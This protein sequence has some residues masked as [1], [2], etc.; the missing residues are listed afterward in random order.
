MSKKTKFTGECQLI[1]VGMME[2]GKCYLKVILVNNWSSHGA[3][4]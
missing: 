3:Q 1:N 4:W 2:L